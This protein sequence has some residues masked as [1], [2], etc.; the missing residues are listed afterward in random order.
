MITTEEIAHRLS[1]PGAFTKRGDNYNEP[2]PAW[3]ARAV[4]ELIQQQSPSALYDEI[5]KERDKMREERNIAVEN[6][7]N[8]RRAVAFQVNHLLNLNVAY[9]DVCE[10]REKIPFKWGF[11]TRS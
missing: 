2:L 6:H 7:A 8:D 11:A 4:M 9:K 3:C 5:M 1:D 10:R